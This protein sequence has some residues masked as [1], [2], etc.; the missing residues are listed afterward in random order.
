MD[1]LCSCLNNLD[2]IDKSENKK[3]LIQGN[4]DIFN[5]LIKNST[6]L[7]TEQLVNSIKQRYTALALYLKRNYKSSYQKFGIEQRII[8]FVDRLNFASDEFIIQN[9]YQIDQEIIQICRF[10]I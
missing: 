9:A 8:D 3:H 10:K 4:N 7:D 5:Y 2:T 1:D 6:N